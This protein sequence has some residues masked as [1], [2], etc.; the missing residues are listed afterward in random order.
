MRR[1]E[2]HAFEPD[3]PLACDTQAVES[4]SWCLHADFHLSHGGPA[5]RTLPTHVA[6]AASMINLTIYT[7]SAISHHPRPKPKVP[8][9]K[10]K[11]HRRLSQNKCQKSKEKKP[12]TQNQKKRKPK[13]P[14]PDSNRDCL[15]QS[16]VRSFQTLVSF[17]TTRPY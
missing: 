7:I 9:K 2:I 15:V 3:E 6:L 16:V 11:G 1:S 10:I 8:K 13:W 14:D 17:H 5:I 4:H 12:V